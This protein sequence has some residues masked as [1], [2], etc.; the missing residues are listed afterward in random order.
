MPTLTIFERDI[1][2]F[3]I[4]LISVLFFLGYRRK[5]SNTAFYFKAHV[6]LKWKQYF[7]PILYE[8]T[9]SNLFIIHHNITLL[10]TDKNFH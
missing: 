8:N 5:N 4:L 6:L 9:S 2:I 7:I 1:L 3:T 10:F